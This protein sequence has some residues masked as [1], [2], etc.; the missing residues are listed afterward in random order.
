VEIVDARPKEIPALIERGRIDGGIGLRRDSYFPGIDLWTE[1]YAVALP[2][3]HRFSEMQ[4]LRA[5]DIAAE[6]M[7]VR[8]G[9]EALAEVSRPFTSRGIRP[10]MSARTDNDERAVSYVRSGLGI[11]VMP[12]CFA[13]EGLS[14][15][16]LAGFGLTR[17]VSVMLAADKPDL[18]AKSQALSC[19]AERL[20]SRAAQTLTSLV[21]GQLEDS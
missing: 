6:T 10:F 9:C 21:S 1:G 3:T 2:K 7:F 19:L 20:R 8:R 13:D 17:T 15:V 18:L 14:L 11:T 16:P 5:A 4:S 12:L